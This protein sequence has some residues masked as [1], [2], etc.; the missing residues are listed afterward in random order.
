M[1]QNTS[2][3]I[4][5]RYEILDGLRGI[6]AV[7]VVWFHIAESYSMNPVDKLINHGYLA[8]DFFFVLSGFVIGYAYDD[9]WTGK[10][11]SVGSFFKRR[12]IRLQPLV[13]LGMVLG[14]FLYYFSDCPS[15]AGVSETTWWALLGSALLSALLIPQPASMNIRG[16]EELSSVNIP[17]WSLIYEY[18]G[19]I[20]YALFLRRLS[21]KGL[22]IVVALF[23]LMLVD[24]ALNL[25]LTGLM[26]THG[27]P[28]SLNGGFFFCPEQIY[29]GM[30]RMGYS[31]CMGL[32]LS[33]LGWAA[34]LKGGFWWCA[35]LIT[36]AICMPCVG[37]WEQPWMD[38]AYNAFCALLLFP[39]V[40]T[41]GAGSK[42]NDKRSAS[43]CNFLGEI[44][45]PLYITHY[46]MMYV[47]FAWI[48]N[49]PNAPFGTHVI[50][51]A[52]VFLLDI[53]IAY[54]ALTLF[55]KPVR[56][57]LSKRL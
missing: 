24:S 12:L 15:Y 18:V 51:S 45:Y 8:V 46:P 9:R 35:L 39:L 52:S 33:R 23:A 47:L 50:V 36:I 21:R 56:A 20:F 41:I 7:L 10:E 31:F 19:N 14:I 55:D 4:K 16:T 30:A 1:Q 22:A 54:A 29:I 13:V 38:G 57:W 28:L 6:A 2:A 34:G 44:S 42:I 25:N 37:G 27:F 17:V 32:L 49:N 43:V 11:M 53:A 3:A 48:E 5:P 26:E 40:V